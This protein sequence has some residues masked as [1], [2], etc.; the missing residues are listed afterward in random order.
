MSQNILW[1]L[2]VED[3]VT[4]SSVFGTLIIGFSVLI[5]LSIKLHRHAIQ[6][7]KGLSWAPLIASSYLLVFGI[8]YILGNMI[9]FGWIENPEMMFVFGLFSVIITPAVIVLNFVVQLVIAWHLRREKR[10]STKIQ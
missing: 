1:G 4:L 8:V 7:D 3:V 5:Y 2:R 9:L 10:D 6:N